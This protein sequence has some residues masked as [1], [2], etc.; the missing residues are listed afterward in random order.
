MEIQGGE[1]SRFSVSGELCLR[2]P[3]YFCFFLASW[4]DALG[5]ATFLGF[6]VLKHR[7]VPVLVVV[8]LLFSDGRLELRWCAW[9]L[10]RSRSAMARVYLNGSG[11]G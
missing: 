1:W 10:A 7:P 9:D 3:R 11:F 2:E 8:V 5:P 6:S 4:A